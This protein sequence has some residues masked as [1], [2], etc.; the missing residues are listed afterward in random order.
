VQGASSCELYQQK[1][2][3]SAV[4]VHIVELLFILWSC[5]C[6]MHMTLDGEHTALLEE[7]QLSDWAA[8]SRLCVRCFLYSKTAMVAAL[9]AASCCTVLCRLPVLSHQP[10]TRSAAAVCLQVANAKVL[11]PTTGLVD[12]AAIA[13]AHDLRLVAQPAA[14][15]ANID[16]DA[17]KQRGI[18]VTIAPGEGE[19]AGSSTWTPQRCVH[20]QLS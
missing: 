6:C 7:M 16:L 4:A 19:T 10:V 17:A 12:A 5:S 9:A 20:Q 11:V 13:A 18:P 1:I 8:T 2:P 15:Y 3:T 14:G